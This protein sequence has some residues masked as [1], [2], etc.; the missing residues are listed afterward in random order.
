MV[1]ND[2]EKR[3]QCLIY[4]NVYR[5]LYLTPNLSETWLKLL[6]TF[7]TDV[8]SCSLWKNRRETLLDESLPLSLY[9]AKVRV[10]S[11]G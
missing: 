8:P 3:E 6:R 9:A 10:W 7:H 2:L 11:Q 5:W 4:F 1:N